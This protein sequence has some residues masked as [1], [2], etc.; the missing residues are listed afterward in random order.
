MKWIGRIA[1]GVVALSVAVI[2][3]FFGASE[4]AIRRPYAIA[5]ENIVADRSE[6]GVREGERLAHV[7]SCLSCHGPQARGHVVIDK[8]MLGSLTAPGLAPIVQQESDAQL[9]RTIRHGVKGNGA[10][11][12]AMPPRPR[13][14]A[15]D[16]ARLIGYLRTL[17]P[18]PEDRPERASFG[19]LGRL[20]ILQGRLEPSVRNDVVGP[21]RRPA[22]A[23][24][25][26][27]NL[28]CLACHDLYHPRRVGPGSMA[29]PLAAMASAYDDAAFTRLMRTGVGLSPHDLGEM[30][31]AAQTGFTHFTDDEIISIKR[32]LG[33]AAETAPN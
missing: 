8:P 5:E 19:P 23:G 9:A 30:R 2:L 31:V 4:W 28:V 14:A 18:T 1:L 11:L 33:K 12:W 10:T 27:V 20:Q 21:A 17:Q 7:L 13:L 26:L 29:P 15:D 32:Y 6:A 3:V 24:P 22:D 16:T 25:Y